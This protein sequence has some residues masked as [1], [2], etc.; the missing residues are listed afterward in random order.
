VS[1]G[2]SVEVITI[3]ADVNARAAYPLG[4][5]EA[6]DDPELADAFVAYVAGPEGQAVLAEHGFLAP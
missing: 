1:A 2:H 6:T 3:P 5:V 4:V